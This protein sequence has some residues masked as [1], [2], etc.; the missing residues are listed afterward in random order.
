MNWTYILLGIC[1]FF[2]SLNLI[3]TFFIGLFIVRFQQDLFK[4]LV[5]FESSLEV[6]P[7][8]K[9]EK[10]LEQK[11]WDQKYEEEL[12]VIAERISKNAEL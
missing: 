1:L 5:N 11:T 2:C 12:S 10:S 6:S 8:A 3:L 9:E 7:P 4:R